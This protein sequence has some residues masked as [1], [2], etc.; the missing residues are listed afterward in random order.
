MLVNLLC[1]P[2]IFSSKLQMYLQKEKSKILG[3]SVIK[4]WE[5]VGAVV[6]IRGRSSPQ[7]LSNT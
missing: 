2:S 1:C 4:S 7:P 6:L 5:V 3:F